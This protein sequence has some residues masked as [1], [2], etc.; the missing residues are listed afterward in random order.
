MIII[1][2]SKEING[3]RKSSNIVSV[4]LN[5]LSLEIKP[6]VT[7]EYLNN[8]AEEIIS[9]KGG[10]PAF[11]GYNG[12]PYTICASVNNQLLHGFPSN[13]PLKHGD[14]LS[15]DVGVCKNGY[16]GD[17]A[18]TLPVGKCKY[19]YL[20]S[21]GKECLYQ[22]IN[23]AISG[24]RLGDISNAIETCAK[25]NGF[26]VIEDFSGHG[27]GMYLHEEPKV[28][29][30][31]S[32]NEGVMLKSGMVI[33]IEPITI[34]KDFDIDRSSNGWTV[35]DKNNKMSVHFEHTI[36]ITSSKPEILT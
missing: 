35:E 8:L 34:E 11:K 15:V 5:K 22:G 3:I 18:V 1:K 6:G 4:V 28:L 9:D 10:I 33:A 23:N 13:E 36:L 12:Y 32:Q 24:N 21:V 31:G 14:L 27:I 29:N 16:Y 7:T 30:C 25:S 2:N 19:N 17:A 26:D 20:L